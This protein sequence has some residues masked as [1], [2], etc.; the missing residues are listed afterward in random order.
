MNAMPTIATCLDSVPLASHAGRCLRPHMVSGGYSLHRGFWV[1][2]T[3]LALL[4]APRIASGLSET[5]EASE[6]EAR[7]NSVGLASDEPI[8]EVV[9]RFNR[10]ASADALKWGVPRQP[11]LTEAEV[12]AALRFNAREGGSHSKRLQRACRNAATSRRLPKG[13]RFMLSTGFSTGTEAGVTG[14]P[15]GVVMWRIVL[16]FFVDEV[17]MMAS[18]SRIDIRLQYLDSTG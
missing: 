15:A 11:E 10:I 1:A 13:S 7:E 8:A 16:Y 4:S 12:V 2:A 6:R 17:P 18:S 9:A 5:D 3:V 14:K